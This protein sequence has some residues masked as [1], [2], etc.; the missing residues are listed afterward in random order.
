MK[1]V[2][3]KLLYLT[4]L[5]CV[6]VFPVTVAAAADSGPYSITLNYTYNGSAIS[7]VTCHIYRV[8]EKSGTSYVLTSDFSESGANIKEGADHQINWADAANTLAVYARA[9]S[10]SISSAGATTDSSGNCTF[11]LSEAGSYLIL[12][13]SRTV[14][15]DTY[16]FSPSLITL[17]DSDGTAAVTA[18]AKVSYTPWSPSGSDPVD[19]T[20]LKVW[21]DGEQEN[22]RPDSIS[23]SLLRDD[24]AFY[25]VQLSESNQWRYTWSNLDPNY[26]WS[27]MENSVPD[28]YGVSYSQNRNIWSITNTYITDILPENPPT[29]GIVPED[30][31]ATDILPGDTPTTDIFP[32]DIPMTALPQTGLLQWPIPVMT[33]LGILL[34]SLGW[35]GHFGRKNHE[36]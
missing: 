10:A 15:G 5:L 13:E 22:L 23:V 33:I 7:G 34:F 28:D 16:S 4:L 26:T 12:G 14:N 30:P 9:N 35:W 18:V 24:S 20:V 31:S 2:L 21:N 36:K 27:V 1:P 19:V 6:V 3:K 8:L 17:P 11:S 25:T 29:S 32:G